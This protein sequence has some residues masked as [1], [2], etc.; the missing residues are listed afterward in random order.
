MNSRRHSSPFVRPWRRIVAGVLVALQV[1]YPAVV[2]AQTVILP[3]GRTQTAVANAGATW[4][5]STATV[6]GSNAFNSFSAFSV[7]GGNTV[8]L[9]VP[10]SSA[11]LIN[12][13]RDQRT[14][15]HGILN[16]IKD[17]R[18]GGNVWFVDS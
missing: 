2:A 3:D 15:V 9:I 16:A 13:V 8:N 10:S 12:I 14:D 17:G 1:V 5:V 7:G 4:N 18:V 6:S 11:N